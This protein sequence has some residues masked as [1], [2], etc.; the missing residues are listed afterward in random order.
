MRSASNAQMLLSGHL[1]CTL[2]VP[3]TIDATDVHGA[4]LDSEVPIHS[5][6]HGVHG[7]KRAERD[8]TLMTVDNLGCH[9]TLGRQ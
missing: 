5:E 6:L 7:S 3:L 4:S 9:S 8:V 1:L 2:A